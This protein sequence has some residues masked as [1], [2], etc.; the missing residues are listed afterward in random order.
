MLRGAERLML[1]R[2]KVKVYVDDEYVW[3]VVRSAYF[4]ALKLGGVIVNS[5]VHFA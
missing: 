5:F 4:V 3:R 1:R 2:V